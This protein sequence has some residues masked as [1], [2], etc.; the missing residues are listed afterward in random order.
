MLRGPLQAGYR[1]H[2]WGLG[3]LIPHTPVPS[4][5]SRV[6]WYYL[7]WYYLGGLIVALSWIDLPVRPVWSRYSLRCMVYK[8]EEIFSPGETV[9]INKPLLSLYGER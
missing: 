3:G 7:A 2:R 4:G 1:P 6:A 5:Q 8:L 9:Y